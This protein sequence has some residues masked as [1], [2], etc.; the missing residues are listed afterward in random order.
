M[1]AGPALVM[2]TG[3]AFA[4]D[5][6]YADELKDFGVSAT[7]SPKLSRY[8]EPTPTQIPGGKLIKTED[9]AAMLGSGTKPVVIVA[10]RAQ[11]TVPGAI[12]MDGAGEGRL[13]GPDLD[14][15]ARALESLTAGDKAKPVVFYCHGPRCWLSYNA[16]LHAMALGYTQVYWYR[17][18]RDAWKAAG[19][20]FVEPAGTW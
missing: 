11:K 7:S 2:L 17:G 20:K 13:L 15:F 5:A 12:V 10:Y 16:A 9:L 19:N 3:A 4:Q 14:K 8:G 1:I 6:G 18:G